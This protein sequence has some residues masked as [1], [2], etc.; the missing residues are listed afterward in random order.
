ME[1]LVIIMFCLAVLCY[2]N[3]TL[4]KLDLQREKVLNLSSE[5]SSWNAIGTL[6]LGP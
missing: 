5:V 2:Y 4:E 6:V 1:Q 3:K